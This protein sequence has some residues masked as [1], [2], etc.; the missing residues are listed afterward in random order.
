M[1]CTKEGNDDSTV[2]KLNRF[3]EGEKVLSR[4]VINKNGIVEGIAR[5]NVLA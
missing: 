5:W 1:D 4:L 2:T 3:N